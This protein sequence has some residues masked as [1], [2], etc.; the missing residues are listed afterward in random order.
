MVLLI[1]K[2]QTVTV[3]VFQNRGMMRI[4]GCQTYEHEYTIRAGKAS[5]ETGTSGM[6]VKNGK[7]VFVSGCGN[8]LVV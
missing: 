3:R 7:A 4:S 2:F 5:W 8:I 6:E 1:F